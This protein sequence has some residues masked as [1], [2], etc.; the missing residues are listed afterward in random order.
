MN[1]FESKQNNELDGSKK[2]ELS[3]AEEEFLEE[4]SKHSVGG[5]T[6]S[7]FVLLDKLETMNLY[8]KILE[9]PRGKEVASNVL[10][11]VLE[12]GKFEDAKRIKGI[13]SFDEKE[14]ATEEMRKA[15]LA[16]VKVRFKSV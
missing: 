8:D 1:N 7:L 12:R 6:G 9:S 11:R 10:K 3:R 16:G 4:F 15:I 5:A 2:I 13:F 14:L